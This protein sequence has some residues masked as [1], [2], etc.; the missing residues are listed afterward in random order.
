MIKTMASPSELWHLR[1]SFTLSMASF[2]FMTYVM[3]MGA[4][5][6]SRIHI[7]RS[8]GKIHTSDMLPSIVPNKP[9]FVN[10]EQVPFRYT[11]NFQRFIGPIGT[12]GVLTS[13][14]LAI[15]R[16]LTESEHDLEHRLSI[17]IREEVLVWAQM[18]KTDPRNT[19]PQLVLSNVDAVVRRARVMSCKMEREKVRVCLFE[20]PVNMLAHRCDRLQVCQFR[21]IKASSSCSC[22]QP[23]FK[24]CRAWKLQ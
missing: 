8:T 12:E 2:I 11:P 9:E 5:V 23:A 21:S 24:I 13:A 3:S 18:S 10:T 6:P 15:A 7:S 19:L 22:K 4:R 14:M 16:C 20:L 17:F 1:K